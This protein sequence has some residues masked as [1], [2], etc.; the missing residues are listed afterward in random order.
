[1]R[2]PGV[3]SVG[4]GFGSG[5]CSVL[6]SGVSAACGLPPPAGRGCFRRSGAGRRK[7]SVMT[8]KSILLACVIGSALWLLLI[9]GLYGLL[10]LTA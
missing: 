7:G 8:F 3:R 10:E 5:G 9:V 2:E 4:A 6:R 1:M